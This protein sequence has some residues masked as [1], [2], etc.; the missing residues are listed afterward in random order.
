MGWYIFKALDYCIGLC[1]TV[2]AAFGACGLEPFDSVNLFG[3]GWRTRSGR[4]YVGDNRGAVGVG[5]GGLWWSPG[6]RP[7]LWVILYGVVLWVAEFLC[8]QGYSVW[9]VL[10]YMAVFF[11]RDCGGAEEV[12]LEDRPGAEGSVFFVCPYVGIC[13]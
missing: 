12:G 13:P 10:G 7:L 8:G 3:V 1:G 2:H 6:P 11:A 9:S 4:G 5:S